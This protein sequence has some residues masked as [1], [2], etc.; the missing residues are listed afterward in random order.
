MPERAIVKPLALLFFLATQRI[1]TSYLYQ[2]KAHIKRL[3]HLIGFL[4]LGHWD[5]F[6]ICFLVLGVFMIFIKQGFF[7]KSAYLLYKRHIDSA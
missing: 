7:V 6:E 2:I 4:N 1:V 3:K 5:L